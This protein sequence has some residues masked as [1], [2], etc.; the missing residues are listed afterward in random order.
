MK[1]T[2]IKYTTIPLLLLLTVGFVG[3]D[4]DK[5]KEDYCYIGK[6]VSH[7]DEYVMLIIV[8]APPIS[9]DNDNYPREG[10]HAG[11]YKSDL[12]N[13][14]FEDGLLISFKITHSELFVDPMPTYGEKYYYY[15][16]KVKPC[17]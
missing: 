4:D 11:F 7:N 12:P 1:T 13:Q 14:V 8:D 15:K 17:N 10:W 16:C 6:V 2:I 5:D 9:T 3:C